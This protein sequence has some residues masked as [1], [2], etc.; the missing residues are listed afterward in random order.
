MYARPLFVVVGIF[1]AFSSEAG[2][3]PAAATDSTARAD[4]G[5]ISLPFSPSS[6]LVPEARLGMSGGCGYTLAI[7]NDGPGLRP[8]LGFVMAI[9]LVLIGSKAK[10]EARD[11]APPG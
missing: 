4:T 2:P 6:H 8:I 7:M 9:C 1:R 11:K 10:R 5:S 3:D